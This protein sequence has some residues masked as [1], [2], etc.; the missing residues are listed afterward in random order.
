MSAQQSR[1]PGL[2]LQNPRKGSNKRMTAISSGPRF[3]R[4]LRLS[5]D[6]RIGTIGSFDKDNK[7][8]ASLAID[9]L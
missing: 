1:H 2:S 8:Q 9:D 3:I 5:I 4:D 6:D 7:Y